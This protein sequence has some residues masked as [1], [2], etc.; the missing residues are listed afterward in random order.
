MLRVKIQM[1]VIHQT[2][3][4]SLQVSAFSFCPFSIIL[5][6]WSE[7]PSLRIKLVGQIANA[8]YS[9]SMKVKLLEIILFIYLFNITKIITRFFFSYTR[10]DVVLMF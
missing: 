5:S 2:G 1:A 10:V 9:S 8:S 7:T 3:Q 6:T 4:R